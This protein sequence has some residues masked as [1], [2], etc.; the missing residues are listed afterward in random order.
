MTHLTV[1]E[2]GSVPVCSGTSC[3]SANA[4]TRFQA[5]ALLAAA[6]AHPIANK[7]GTN[8]L[9]DHHTKIIAQQMVGVIAAPGCSLEILPKIDADVNEPNTTVRHR[10]VRMLSVALD[11]N[12]G[13]GQSAT[14][15]RQTTSLLDIMIRLFTDQL[16][17]EA[18]RGL[19][20][21]YQTEED[22]LPALRGKLDVRRQFTALAVRPD[23]LAC[24]YD[25]LLA[26]TALLRIMKVCVLLL[27]RYAL[28][29]ESIRRLDELRFLLADVSDVS[30]SN[31]P[32]AKV[33][34]DRTNRRWGPLYE[35][36]RLFLR[37]EWQ[38]THHDRWERDGISLL[39]PMNDLFEAY[40]AALT[41]RALDGTALSVLAQG[42]NLCCLVEEGE[43]GKQVF[44]TKPDL[45][46]KQGKNTV[47]VIDTKWKRISGKDV[48]PKRGIK[49]NDVYQLM[50]YARLY[51]SPEV[52]L[53]YP[54]HTGLGSNIV[55]AGYRIR[56][57]EE[58][59]RVASINL[60][61]GEDAVIEQ[62]A[63]L[64]PT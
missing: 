37:R 52:M 23:R 16:L 10:L 31:L 57:G 34:I 41:K 22:D 12:I 43:D 42:G 8:I 55:N 49:E 28:A 25:T 1:Y 58:R 63:S 24:R 61:S 36:A 51:R 45:L 13:N 60:M 47:M 35:M 27:R 32:W 44:K 2:W 50:A 62:L 39:F 20:R 9:I 48:D 7:N 15:A 3:E 30:I 17:T 33:R 4:F 29:S 11:L 14:M 64:L 6:R 26:D 46:I 21:A 5:N 59:L 54:H 40:I 19:P 53:L 38:A 18:R 56:G